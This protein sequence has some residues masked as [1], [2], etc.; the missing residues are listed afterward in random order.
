MKL[1]RLFHLLLAVLVLSGA[2]GAADLAE[3]LDSAAE[4]GL[5]KTTVADLARN[6]PKTFRFLDSTKRRIVYSPGSKSKL[7][8]LG[9]PVQ[10]ISIEC[11]EEGRLE[12]VSVSIYSRGDHGKWNMREFNDAVRDLTA[13]FSERFDG[14]PPRRESS[15]LNRSVIR[16][17]SWQND[18][19]VLSMRYSN[20]RNSPE[21]ITVDFDPPG[22]GG[23]IRQQMRTGIADVAELA[24]RVRT[25]EDGA[26]FFLLPMVD[27][28]SKGYCVPAVAARVL[29]YYG[30]DIDQH[31]VAQIMDTRA[32]GGTAS[33]KVDEIFRR[34]GPRLGYRY[35]ELYKY[36]GF[37]GR[38]GAGTL[39]DY[40]RLARRAGKAEMKI[41][42][43][44]GFPQ[45]DY[46]LF[47]ALRARDTR[48]RTRFINGIRANVSR[49][50]PVCWGVMTFPE[51]EKAAGDKIGFHLRVINGYNDKTGEIVYTD[52]WG[53]GHEAKTMRPDDAWAITLSSFV[54]L[55]RPTSSGIR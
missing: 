28:G 22:G 44:S 21:Y 7:V 30:S 43:I 48:G 1:T 16:Q 39:R 20:D 12:N 31:V 53:P 2:A 5:W 29:G 32:A 41:G 18:Q 25:R 40:N 6:Y 3:W 34:S 23:R 38:K 50:V 35:D 24:K 11:S 45:F 49:G 14:R 52:S 27:Q 36:D 10:E 42:R 19:V 15:S 33:D 26:R 46:E 9:Y 13:R 17:N 54:L 55:P 8:W 4:G 37:E 47:K 51:L